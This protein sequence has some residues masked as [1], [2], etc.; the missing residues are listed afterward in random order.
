MLVIML[1]LVGGLRF[2]KFK[3]V[4]AAI[5]QGKNFKIPPTAVAIVSRAFARKYFPNQDPIGHYLTPKF[6]YSTEPILVLPP[7][8]FRASA[9][10]A[11]AAAIAIQPCLP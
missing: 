11:C 5:E 7:S 6:E 8:T 4:E 3:Q 9:A 10:A 1:A 2:V